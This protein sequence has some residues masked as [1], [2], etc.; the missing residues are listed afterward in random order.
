MGRRNSESGRLAVIWLATAFVVVIGAAAS[1]FVIIAGTDDIQWPM[2]VWGLAIGGL[3][4]TLVS[5]SV[6]WDQPMGRLQTWLLAQ[7][8][9]DPTDD[10]R[11]ARR[12]SRA[13]EEIEAKQPPSVESVREA[14]DHGGAWVPRSVPQSAKREHR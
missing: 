5:L 9:S 6:R 1:A 4:F 14:A 10:Y 3:I 8:R 13:R 2:I 11:A 12:R 7:N